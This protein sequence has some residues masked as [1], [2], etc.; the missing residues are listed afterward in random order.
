[1]VVAAA[2]VNK[3]G[4]FHH[5][6]T[7]SNFSS[8]PSFSSLPSGRGQV[9]RRGAEKNPARLRP[10]RQLPCRSAAN[11]PEWIITLLL[12]HSEKSCSKNNRKTPSIFKISHAPC[13]NDYKYFGLPPLAAC[14]NFS[15]GKLCSDVGTSRLTVGKFKSN[16]PQPILYSFYFMIS[17]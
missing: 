6:S 9:E 4:F 12:V 3:V 14:T 7:M 11:N 2:K 16:H 8:F 15:L 1:M 13:V 10:L 5:E 17:F